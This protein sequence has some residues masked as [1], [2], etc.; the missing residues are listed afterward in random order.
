MF[1]KAAQDFNVDLSK[2]WM[3]GDGEN[4]ILAGQN[5]GCRTVLIG[6]QDFRQDYTVAT[7]KE[8]ADKL[9]Q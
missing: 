9:L 1:F 5:A 6:D 4:D 7:L 8:F 3:I 2:S